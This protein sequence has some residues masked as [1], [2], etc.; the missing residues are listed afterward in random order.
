MPSDS[1]DFLDSDAGFPRP[2]H[3]LRNLAMLSPLLVMIP[4]AVLLFMR[5]DREPDQQAEVR[6]RTLQAAEA[7]WAS[8]DEEEQAAEEAKENVVEPVVPPA[9]LIPTNGPART[10]EITIAAAPAETPKP[11]EPVKTPEPKKEE[12][13]PVIV[14]GTLPAKPSPSPAPVPVPG[15]PKK[16]S[17]RHLV[18]KGET[19]YSIGKLYG[20]S[21][22]QLASYNR[23]QV[24]EP[25][26]EGQYLRLAPDAKPAPKPPQLP[27]P[28]KFFMNLT[29]VSG[30]AATMPQ[31]GEI[32]RLPM[33]YI[34]Y[35]VQKHD[36]MES[37]AVA[38]GASA[39]TIAVLNG[40]P[41]VTAGQ[42]IVIPLEEV[43]EWVP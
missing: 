7:I 43:L 36:T 41:E 14:I 20:K 4:G 17:D 34:E 28:E 24:K 1:S 25:I 16:A 21:P 33:Y 11:A 15:T 18:R 42:T 35:L 13:K 29:P 38:H 19:L 39:Q 30:Q 12:E 37:I 8:D 32:R 40:T 27:A 6:A 26:R 3:A 9:E 22:D 23:M 10:P 5:H 2:R 31:A